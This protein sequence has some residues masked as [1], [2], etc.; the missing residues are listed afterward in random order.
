MNRARLGE[1]VKGR[2]IRHLGHLSTVVSLIGKQ[3]STVF[4]L[5]FAIVR[6]K[7]IELPPPAIGRAASFYVQ[8][9]A[10]IATA[11]DVK[12]FA[13]VDLFL[14]VVLATCFLCDVGCRTT[15][16]IFAKRLI[17]PLWHGGRE[18]RSASSASSAGSIR[19]LRQCLSTACRIEKNLRPFDSVQI[20]HNPPPI[21]SLSTQSCI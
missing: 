12:I 19:S 9:S 7:P 14:A 1:V 4:R 18:R 10:S 5:P 20:S 6:E 3:T 21:P 16:G 11:G 15:L 13:G 17:A 8:N 2:R